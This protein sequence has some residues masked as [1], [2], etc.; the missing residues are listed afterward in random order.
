MILGAWKE[1]SADSGFEGYDIRETSV[2]KTD[3]ESVRA[4][5]VLCEQN[6]CGEYGTTWACPPGAGPAAACV[7][8][9]SR[10]TKA[11]LITK[12]YEDIDAGDGALTMRLGKEMQDVCR[13]FANFLRLRGLGVFPMADVGCGFCGLCA[14][15]DGPCRFPAQRVASMGGYGIMMDKFLKGNGIPF[16]FEKDAATFYGIILYDPRPPR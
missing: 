10:Y 5:R 11:A 9:V 3:E 14:Y 13:R 16:S 2:P 6:L 4:C 8:E 1:F 15:P 12:R 7:R